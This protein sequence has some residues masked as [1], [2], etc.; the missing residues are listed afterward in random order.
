MLYRHTG[1]LI[2]LI[3]FGG[4][5]KCSIS[6]QTVNLSRI[7]K[8]YSKPTNVDLSGDCHSIDCSLMIRRVAM[9]Y[10]HYLF[11]RNPACSGL[12][13]LSNA[14]FNLSKISPVRTLL[15]MDKSMITRQFPRCDRS[16]FFGHL[17]CFPSTWTY[18]FSP[19]LL[20]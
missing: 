18:F 9:W 4:I 13:S 17:S 5:P 19:C 6:F 10:V 2:M 8:A 15:A 1:F 11:W 14:S 3:N 16:S 20:W 12:R 7:S